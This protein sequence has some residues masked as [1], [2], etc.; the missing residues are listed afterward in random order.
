M[1]GPE[2]V[3]HQQEISHSTCLDARHFLGGASALSG[4]RRGS[5]FLVTAL[6]I[7]C[8]DVGRRE[9]AQT[10]ALATGLSLMD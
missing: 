4:E 10:L 8:L 6:T 7:I 3:A 1:S 9:E 2:S 5:P